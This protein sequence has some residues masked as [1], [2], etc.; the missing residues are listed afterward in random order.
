[1]DASS[2]F[3]IVAFETQISRGPPNFWSAAAKFSPAEIFLSVRPEQA[4]ARDGK[5]SAL[6][7]DDLPSALAG[8]GALV[9]QLDKGAFDIATKGFAIPDV[10]KYKKNAEFKALR[11][12]LLKQAAGFYADL[13]K[14][15]PYAVTVQIKTE[16]HPLGK[17][18]D[19]DLK[20]LIGILRAFLWL[21]RL[22]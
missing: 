5:F 18:Q 8:H 22:G 9:K 15:A 11:T 20:R 1:M 2:S 19:A 12:K 14:L 10:M 17:R 4:W 16:I 7:F 13:E 6:L 21:G 3:W